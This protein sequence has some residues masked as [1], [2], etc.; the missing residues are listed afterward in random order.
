MMSV[1]T[2]LFT[3]SAIKLFN[4]LYIVSAFAITVHLIII[5]TLI[6]CWALKLSIGVKIMSF[7]FAMS[8]LL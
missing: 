6:A 7:E 2:E 1:F 4:T 8:Q 5:I 3:F